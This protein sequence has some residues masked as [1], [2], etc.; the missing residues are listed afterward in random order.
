MQTV[1]DNSSNEIHT[2]YRGGCRGDARNAGDFEYRWANLPLA[3]RTARQRNNKFAAGVGE[4]EVQAILSALAVRNRGVHQF[5]S[6]LGGGCYRHYVPAAVRAITA[7]A[8]FATGYTPYQPEAS[9][10]TTQAIFEFQTLIAQLTGQDVA[11]ASM[12]DGASASA[13]AVLMARRLMPKR[14]T[15]VLSRALWPDYRA[16]IR[17]Y[18]GVQPEIRLVELPFDSATGAA[19][20]GTLEKLADDRLLCT[21]I[22]YPNAFG[23]IE[24]I[25]RIAQTVHGS[26][27]LL[28]S[29]T[30]EA[31]A[32]GL[33]KSPAELGVDI[34]VGEGQ[35]F[36]I[37]PQFGGPGLGFMATRLAHVR[38]MPARR[39]QVMTAI[40]CRVSIS[41][42]KSLIFLIVAWH[43]EHSVLAKYC[44]RRR[45]QLK[46]VG[47]ASSSEEIADLQLTDRDVS[48]PRI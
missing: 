32:L 13:E 33:L 42:A 26:G 48:A 12:Y 21:V 7:R 34:A 44:F 18:L 14:S 1:G 35:S 45:R 9:Q 10:G 29:A 4:P 41:H 31:L 6:F 19:D 15:V 24:P 22:G 8:E 28:I 20:F 5:A 2:E 40:T 30:A 36:G 39:W 37:A 16:T 11:N 38:Q 27:G 43:R 3:G 23:V 47:A 17:T 46:T 25:G